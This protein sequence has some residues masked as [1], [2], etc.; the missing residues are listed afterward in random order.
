MCPGCD[1]T[2]MPQGPGGVQV[3]E[4]WQIAA[5]H[6]LGRAN[7]MLQSAPVLG[8]GNRVPDGDGGSDD[9]GVEVHQHCL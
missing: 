8:S 9:G 6:L 1:L 7:D 3:L 2:C 5:S 4:Q